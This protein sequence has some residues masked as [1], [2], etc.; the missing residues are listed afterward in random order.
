M[1]KTVLCLY[2]LIQI[3]LVSNVRRAEMSSYSEG[4]PHVEVICGQASQYQLLT[5]HSVGF[6]HSTRG[7]VSLSFCEGS[8]ADVSVTAL[9]EQMLYKGGKRPKVMCC[10]SVPCVWFT[11]LSAA[12]QERRWLKETKRE[13]GAANGPQ[14]AR[15]RDGDCTAPRLWRKNSF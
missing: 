2:R 7:K 5:Y 11:G 9:S 14:R 4:L 13:R 12:L 10:P 15:I 6:A 1:L 3:A 8:L